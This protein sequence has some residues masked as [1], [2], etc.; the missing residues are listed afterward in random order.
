MP[1]LYCEGT[2]HVEDMVLSSVG[3]VCICVCDMH[4]RAKI[5]K[6]S[7]QTRQPYQ[8]DVFSSCNIYYCLLHNYN[9]KDVF[10]FELLV[11]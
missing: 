4:C 8:L 1:L 6:Q 9:R 3:C 2:A 11:L 5:A 7:D 10:V